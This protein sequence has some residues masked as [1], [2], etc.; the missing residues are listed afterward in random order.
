[1]RDEDEREYVEYVTARR[2]GLPWAAYL[3]CGDGH[4]ADDIVQAAITSLYRKWHR[5]RAGGQ[6]RRVRAPHPGPQVPR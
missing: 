3:M 6:Q 4:R 1:M 2:A 5:A